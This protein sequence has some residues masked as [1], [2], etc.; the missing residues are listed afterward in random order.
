MSALAAIVRRDLAIALRRGGHVGVVVA[1]FVLVASLF[2]LGVGPELAVLRRIGSGVIW[3]AALLAA[4]LSLDRLFQADFEDGS[5]E[6]LVLAPVALEFVVL[7][8]A[9]AHWLTT[10][11][12]LL[13]A[14]PVL[15]LLFDLERGTLLVMVLAMA[16]GSPALSLMGAIG[17]ALTLGLRR[18]GV[19]VSLLVLPL[20]TP[21]LIFGVGAVEAA[22]T[23]TPARTHLLI[24]GALLLAALALTPWATAAALRSAME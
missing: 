12:P 10:G 4:M 15:G 9:L 6:Q 11:V 18:G 19:L 17:A 8:K 21:I 13:L 20:V 16:L 5:L 22:A 23:G 14:A 24:L 3:V 2:P 7:A 1:F